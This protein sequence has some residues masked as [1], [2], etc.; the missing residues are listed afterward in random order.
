MKDVS[1]VLFAFGSMK[2]PLDDLWFKT[3]DAFMYDEAQQARLLNFVKCT[4][5]TVK[6]RFFCV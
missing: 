2:L 3:A 6:V 4:R 1:R 5:V